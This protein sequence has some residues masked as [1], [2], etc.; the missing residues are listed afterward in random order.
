MGTW[1]PAIQSNDT[2]ADIYYLFFDLFQKGHSVKE[3]SAKLVSENADT[4]NEEDDA[5]NFWLAL[6][7]AQWET[8]E[9]DPGVLSIVE[10]IISGGKDL[11]AWKRLGADAKQLEK[12][13]QKLEQFLALI[14]T[15]NK[16]PKKKKKPPKA[17]FRPG[18]CLVIKAKRNHSSESYYTG[19]IVLATED[20]VNL[21]AKV[22]VQ[23]LSTPVLDDFLPYQQKLNNAEKLLDLFLG[24]YK[25]GYP[26]WY[27]VRT[28]KKYRDDISSVGVLDLS[29]TF[30]TSEETESD[31]DI[32][33][34]WLNI[35]FRKWY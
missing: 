33:P 14:K 20:E 24:D 32:D 26:S 19:A 1:G 28:F 35:P 34:N 31:F 13:G 17:I 16:K 3:I 7:K 9:L 2:S 23:K 15:E 22:G 30:G 18:E 10:D 27:L 5:S 11:A 25:I 4:I 29:V 21:V 6:A 12:R 8:G